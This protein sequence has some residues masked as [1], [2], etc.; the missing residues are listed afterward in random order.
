MTHDAN[1]NVLDVGRRTRSVPTPIRRALGHRDHGRCRFPGCENRVCDAHHLKHWADGGVTKL[2]NL[3]LLCT[4]HHTL[5]HEGGFCVRF[6]DSGRVCFQ[7]RDGRQI[8]HVP[9]GLELTADA[10]LEHQHDELGIEMDAWTP[11]PDW[12]GERLDLE[13]ALM[14]LS[15]ILSD[16]KKK[17]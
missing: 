9:R 16:A 8:P 14:T 2:T 12:H 10:S 13:F 6:D 11:T 17:S 15:R 3:L 4:R 7:Q 5:V 1:G